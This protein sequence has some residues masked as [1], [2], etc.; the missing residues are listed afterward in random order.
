MKSDFP[1]GIFDSGI[2]GLTVARE[3]TE[4]MPHEKIVY[5]GDTLH[6]PYGQKSKQNII[7]YCSKICN[8]LIKKKCKA[9]IIACNTASSIALNNIKNKL[10]LINTP[11]RI[12]C[13]DISNTQGT[14]AV[15]SMVV[16]KNC[17]PAKKILQ[18]I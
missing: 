8:F 5:Y 7:N 11:V 3:I 2:G 12:E 10:E 17:E 4:L 9:I 13:F 1:I 18:E 6:L 16:F 14:N 15:A